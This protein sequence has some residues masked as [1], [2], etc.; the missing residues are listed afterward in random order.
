MKAPNKR[1]L[2][3]AIGWIAVAGSVLIACFWAAWGSIEAFHEGWYSHSF[4]VNVALTLT[5]YL[6]PMVLFVL[7]GA[8]SV[9]WRAAG[10]AFHLGLAVFVVFF[11]HNGAGRYLIA[12]PL[13]VLSVCYWL[14]RPHPQRAALWLVVTA[15]LFTAVVCGAGP[16]W[17]VAHRVDDGDYGMRRI[18]GN[19]VELTWAPEGPGWPQRGANWFEAAHACS[20]LEQDGTALAAVPQNLWRLP[21]ADECVRSLVRHGRNAGGVLDPNTRMKA[22]YQMQ[23][24]K[25]TPLWNPHSMIIYWWTSTESNGNR[26][27]RV[28]CNGWVNELSKKV[29]E[30]EF[31]FR[32]VRP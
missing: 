15:P 28:T 3:M 18:T 12:F 4:W 17:R 10:I 21:T 23:P 32:C 5:Q 8:L 25:E 13:M 1:R 30:G 11:F 16:A 27:L 19:G 22:T 6:S 7:A 24:D 31:S 14:G 26:A 9:K 20:Y 29:R 2:Q